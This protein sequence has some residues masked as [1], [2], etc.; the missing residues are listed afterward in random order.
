M[1][2]GAWHENGGSSFR[3]RSRWTFKTSGRGLSTR[4][5]RSPF[6]SAI[7]KPRHRTHNACGRAMQ[8]RAKRN[9]YSRARNKRKTPATERVE[10]EANAH[11]RT[12]HD[13]VQNGR[14]ARI[15]HLEP[16]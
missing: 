15:Y 1:F 16:A 11:S 12:H 13:A 8:D 4:L 2:P 10:R 7:D 6:D 9:A 3:E 14:S 5:E